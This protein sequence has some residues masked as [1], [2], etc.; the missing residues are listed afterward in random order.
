MCVYCSRRVWTRLTRTALKDE[1]E[2]EDGEDE[3]EEPGTP[4]VAATPMDMDET[5]AATP[6]S[7]PPSRIPPTPQPHGQRLLMY[8]CAIHLI[9]FTVALSARKRSPSPPAIRKQKYLN[10]VR[11]P[12]SYTVEAICALPHP[13]P[14]HALA[15]S[16]CMTHLITGS[17]DG[18]IRDYDIYAAV[19]GKNFLTTQQR[20]HCNVIEGTVKAGQIRCWWENPVDTGGR[21]PGAPRETRLAPVFSLLM[22]SDALW[23]LAG[24]DVRRTCLGGG[25]I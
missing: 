14:T 7:E 13:V 19:N 22:H 10:T 15:S 4:S 21:P 1:S 8:S 9:A 12:K 5:P 25:V 23:S 20:H 3:D 18:Y 11:H 17:D 16:L 6:A 2:D 24:S